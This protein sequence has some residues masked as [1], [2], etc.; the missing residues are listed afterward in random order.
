MYNFFRL[1]YFLFI[2][3]F[4]YPISAQIA[5]LKG[6]NI[7]GGIIFP[8]EWD[9]G[10]NIGA[11]VDLGE[12]ASEVHL[13]PKLTYWKASKGEYGLSNF[14]IAI[15][16]QYFAIEQVEGLYIGIGI[17]YNFLSWDY[18]Y[19]DYDPVLT[20]KMDQTSD[21][22]IGFNPILGYQRM[23]NV[24]VAFAELKYN[25]I[26]EFDTLQFTIGVQMPL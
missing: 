13:A 12:V 7:H 11:G 17:S 6:V 14:V 5:G 1:F 25:L 9:K 20:E 24:V 21:N 23:I 22:R 19:I 16:L 2:L 4:V 8:E 10:F 18:V 15:D 26:S 3:L